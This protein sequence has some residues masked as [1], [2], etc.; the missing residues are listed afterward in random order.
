VFPPETKGVP[1]SL[2]WEYHPWLKPPPSL[3]YLFVNPLSSPTHLLFFYVL[4]SLSS[5]CSSHCAGW[6]AG[7]GALQR[8]R[9]ARPTRDTGGGARF[10]VAREADPNA[11]CRTRQPQERA[12]GPRFGSMFLISLW[13][14]WIKCDVNLM[15]NWICMSLR[16]WSWF[17]WAWGDEI[18]FNKFVW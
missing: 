16:R 1:F 3:I 10:P 5:H 9:G 18:A 15:W 4:F 7:G 6:A 8:R 2:G 14:L 12:S 11:Q 13:F 17:V